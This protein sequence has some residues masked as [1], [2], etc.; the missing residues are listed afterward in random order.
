MNCSFLLIILH[1]MKSRFCLLALFIVLM[2]TSASQAQ[3][4]Q[5]TDAQRV[6]EV[7]K[8]L[9]VSQAQIN[10]NQAKI[11]AKI[12]DLA[13]TIRVAKIEASRSGEKHIPPPK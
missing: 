5:T 8:A 10:D 6:L 4:P 7:V 9:Q 3:A 12:A 2:R 13:E 11:N 1:G